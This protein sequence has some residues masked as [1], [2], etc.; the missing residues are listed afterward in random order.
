MKLKCKLWDLD[1]M[2]TYI[3]LMHCKLV[4]YYYYDLHFADEDIEATRG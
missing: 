1:S 3:C 2:T 4:H